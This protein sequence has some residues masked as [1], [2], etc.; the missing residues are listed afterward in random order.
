MDGPPFFG[1]AVFITLGVIALGIEIH[2]GARGETNN[3]K[4]AFYLTIYF[5]ALL[6]LMWL[7]I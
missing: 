4:G 7:G 6:L 2:K 5:A 1:A 3:A